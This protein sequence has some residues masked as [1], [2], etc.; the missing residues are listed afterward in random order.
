MQASPDVVNMKGQRQLKKAMA[1][2]L[3]SNQPIPVIPG[4]WVIKP[5]LTLKIKSLD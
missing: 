2:I 3:R 5:G 4:T 1:N